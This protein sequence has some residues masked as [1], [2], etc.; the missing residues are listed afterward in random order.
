MNSKRCCK[1]ARED[2][3]HYTNRFYHS[4]YSLKVQRSFVPDIFISGSCI[5]SILLGGQITTITCC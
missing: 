4:L 2:S 3:H 1:R 5:D